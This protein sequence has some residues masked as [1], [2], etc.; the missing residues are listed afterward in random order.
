MVK[1]RQFRGPVCAVLVLA[2]ILGVGVRFEAN[3]ESSG[4]LQEQI[5]ALKQQESE[6]ASQIQALEDSMAENTQEITNI[7]DRKNSIDRQV[8][9]LQE[10]IENT[11]TQI[12][13]YSALI[14]DTQ[15]ELE[16]AEERLSTLQ[17]KHIERIRAMEEEGQL[18]YWSILF[19]ANS[20]ADFLDGINMVQEI[21]AADR[22]RLQ[23][24]KD[25]K[26]EVARVQSELQTHKDALELTRQDQQD[27]QQTLEEKRA[28]ADVLLQELLSKGEEYQALMEQSEL[29]QEQL[30]QELAQ[31]EQAYDE[32]VYR[33]WLATSIPETT[34]P[35]VS[36]Q[37][38][39]GDEPAEE[40]SPVSDSEW[41]TPVPWYI[42]TS[43]FGLRLHPILNIW[44]MHNGVDLACSEG[45][46]IYAS[47]SGIVS[48]ADYQEYGAGNY[49]QLDHGDGYRSIYM[50]MTYYIVS[51][52]EYVN[53]GQTIGFVGSTGLS[54]G[55]HLHFG[56]SY[57][58]TY[59]NPMEYI[60]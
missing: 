17:S 36:T 32:A 2:L 19:R 43:P 34:A 23:E 48:V 6:L 37:P 33:E 4:V 9:L 55:N 15:E 16:E 31:K 5:D 45:T 49:V 39:Q 53:A 8:F 56:I 57:N 10:Q 38:S 14:A 60:D 11:N 29:K 25:A 40:D 52:G 20:F 28:E 21:A 54:D 58:G 41:L 12:S 50:H 24:L 13:A 46:P 26:D 47:R 35:T 7:V 18:S 44:R 1:K 27:Q 42:L 3:A 59:V 22:R 30:M 51:P